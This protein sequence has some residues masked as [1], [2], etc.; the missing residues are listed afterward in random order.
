MIEPNARYRILCLFQKSTPLL[1]CLL[2]LV[3]RLMPL[4][5]FGT[6]PV[7]FILIPLFYWT[8][9]FPDYITPA[10]VF[11]IGLLGDLMLENLFGVGTMGLL[12]FYLMITLERRF[13]MGR[14]FSFLWMI[15]AVYSCII[16]VLEWGLTC[17]LSGYV[18]PCWNVFLCWLVLNLFYPI[19]VPLLGRLNDFLGEE[20]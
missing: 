15:F 4:P 5:L 2:L 20:L 19:F 11:F 12:V 1:I 8:L 3:L 13:F 6:F 7:P 17:V 9:F 10:F 16:I 14:S 18:F